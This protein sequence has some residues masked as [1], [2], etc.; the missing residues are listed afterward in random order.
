MG[1]QYRQGVDGLYAPL[2]AG[3]TARAAT[4]ES[5]NRDQEPTHAVLERLFALLP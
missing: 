1:E 5:V 4:A 3:R 2:P